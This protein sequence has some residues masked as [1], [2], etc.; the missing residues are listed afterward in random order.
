MSMS[1]RFHLERFVEA[2]GSIFPQAL[3]ELERGRKTSH[4]MWFVFPQLAG[5]GRSETARF[6]GIASAG[7]ARQYLAHLVLGPR[8]VRCTQAVLL[9]RGRAAEAIFGSVDALK[10]RSSMTLFAEVAEEH[11]PFREA[12]D[13]FYSG[14]PDAATLRLLGGERQS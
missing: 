1:D 13:A 11:G 7:E 12:L 2:Q 6:Y 8:L 4:W 3:A 9:H 10:F 5:L 14:E